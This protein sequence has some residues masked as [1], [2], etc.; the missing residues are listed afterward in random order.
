M[1]LRC[2]GWCAALALIG[3]FGPP[4][5]RAGQSGA[6]ASKL[7]AAP[8]NHAF[9]GTADHVHV[10]GV[11]RS[12]LDRHTLLITLRIDPGYHVNANPP[13]TENLIPTSIAFAGVVPE[14]IAYPPPIAF[15]PRFSDDTLDVYDG[16]IVIT[17][18]FAAGVLDRMRNLCFTV[19]AQ[20]CTAE[21][22]LPPDEISANA[23]W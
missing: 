9:G 3:A 5:L 14:R 20:A 7:A 1:L 16:N 2:V 22:C 21:I 12:A 6:P 15:K 8:A 23:A 10:T 18:T 13:S 19:T 4:P 11:R 17:A